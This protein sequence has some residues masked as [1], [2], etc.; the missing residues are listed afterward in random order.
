MTHPRMRLTDRRVFAFEDHH[1]LFFYFCRELLPCGRLLGAL[2]HLFEGGGRLAAADR[3]FQLRCQVRVPALST[4]LTHQLRACHP[5][6]GRSP[7]P[8]PP[9]RLAS[10]Y[11]ELARED[12]EGWALG[13]QILDAYFPRLDHVLSKRAGSIIAD[14]YGPKFYTSKYEA[15]IAFLS[16][17]HFDDPNSLSARML[18]ARFTNYG[19]FSCLALIEFMSDPTNA[20]AGTLGPE[21]ARTRLSSSADYSS[22]FDRNWMLL[23]AAIFTESLMHETGV[24]N[25]AVNP[26]TWWTEQCEEPVSYRTPIEVAQWTAD[27]RV[28]STFD[29]T[30]QNSVAPRDIS[31]LVFH[32]SL[33][34]LRDLHTPLS[35]AK[36]PESPVIHI[37]EGHF[38]KGTSGTPRANTRK[39]DR[40][41]LLLGL[42]ILAG[43]LRSAAQAGQPKPVTAESLNLGI[44][45]GDS[46]GEDFAEDH[47]FMLTN[48]VSKLLRDVICNP[49][50]ALTIEDAM[51]DP[52]PFDSPGD[53]RFDSSTMLRYK[54][55]QAPASLRGAGNFDKE[56]VSSHA[57]DSSSGIG[58]TYRERSLQQWVYLTSS[59]DPEVLPGWHR[60]ADVRAWPNLQCN[61]LSDQTCGY[62]RVSGSGVNTAWQAHAEVA[63]LRSNIQGLFASLSSLFG[64]RASEETG[65]DS[66]LQ[67]Y[68][69]NE[70]TTEQTPTAYLKG[71]EALLNARCS[72]FLAANGIPGAKSCATA[73]T[74]W[75]K[76]S[77]FSIGC[78]DERLELLP[79]SEYNTLAFYLPRFASPTPPPRPPPS[80]PPPSPPVSPAPSPPPSP[81]F[82]AS[83][84]DAIE[85]ANKFQQ[86]F[87]DSVYYISAEQRC[88]TLALELHA[89]FDLR[90]ATW[91]PPSLPPLAQSTPP[92]PPPPPSPPTPSPPLDEQRRIQRVPVTHARLSTLFMPKNSTTSTETDSLALPAPNEIDFDLTSSQLVELHSKLDEVEDEHGI[93]AV[94]A[95]T[96]ELHDLGAPLPCRSGVNPIRCLD[97]SRHCGTAAENGYRPFLELGFADYDSGD[98]YFFGVE[99]H[100]PADEQL[101]SLFFH[102]PTNAG[103]DVV[104]NR[105]WEMLLLDDHRVP[106]RVQCQFWNVGGSAAEHVE[107][108]KVVFHTC[109][110]ASASDADYQEL[111]RARF[112]VI[113]LIG[114]LRQF[115]LENV[116][117]F[118]REIVDSRL[119]PPP[120]PVPPFTPSPPASPPDLTLVP[121]F[122]FYPNLAYESYQDFV[123][124]ISLPCGYLRDECAR[125]AKMDGGNAFLLS[126]TGCCVVLDL[127]A[128]IG[129]PN[130]KFQFGSS[131]TGVF[132]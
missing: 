18:Q 33:A 12:P 21:A 120:P 97:G 71:T 107:G 14:K 5:L 8:P 15:T 103:G 101:G 23:F 91:N 53:D 96:D 64:R 55:L 89:T 92:P 46:F 44:F 102:P 19:H 60:L 81:P 72:T 17:E 116:R 56:T 104:E 79:I 3:P 130:V 58:L 80:S 32:G 86:A 124:P 105:G 111:R 75:Y 30:L 88:R 76:R 118:F 6:A 27:P 85:F 99:F 43:A 73:D 61:E 67:F 66:S 10:A 25:Q 110:A 77:S 29:G 4:P 87:C 41:S 51:G 34:Q 35:G 9:A 45:Y 39:R 63:N 106:L 11:A 40:R 98:R 49:T 113:T 127:P 36:Y 119:Q 24:T 78:S 1:R 13:E 94:A 112:V 69:I 74:A 90:D 114:N 20:A 16:T 59:D 22:R 42:G 52:P 125:E 109:L 121:D 95:C 93:D 83:R 128:G 82:F 62:H 38:G 100:L 28:M 57:D 31:P 68:R 26:L 129:T 131:G 50:H 108:L 123:S 115:W 65:Q 117:V 122:D 47:D 132:V 2:R 84:N 37:Y 70:D 54:D 7:P 48:P 126:A